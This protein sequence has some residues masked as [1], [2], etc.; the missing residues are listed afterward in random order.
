MV[1]NNPDVGQ[2]YSVQ[3]QTDEGE[4]EY[5]PNKVSKLPNVTDYSGSKQQMNTVIEQQ[6][7]TRDKG[8]PVFTSFGAM[9]E[10]LSIKGTPTE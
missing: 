3:K 2:A 9:P 8:H 1:A 5:S 10:N 4:E 7:F 6:S